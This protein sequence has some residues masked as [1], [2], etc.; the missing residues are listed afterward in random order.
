[1]FFQINASNAAFELVSQPLLLQLKDTV[2]V[3][4][5]LQVAL[6]QRFKFLE[7]CFRC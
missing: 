6:K 2:S 7:E 3:V 5:I 1:M 4:P